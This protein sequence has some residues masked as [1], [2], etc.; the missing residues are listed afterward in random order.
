[1]PIKKPK[2][3]SISKKVEKTKKN[4]K[5]KALDLKNKNKKSKTIKEGFDTYIKEL[6]KKSFYSNI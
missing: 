1:M 2:T 3:K 6:L 5:A 4:G